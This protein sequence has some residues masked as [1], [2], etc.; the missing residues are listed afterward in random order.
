MINFQLNLLTVITDVP[1]EIY[2]KVNNSIKRVFLYSH[3]V[4]N[5]IITRSEKQIHIH[6]IE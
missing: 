2:L 6:D 5:L 3:Q 1:F 4:D